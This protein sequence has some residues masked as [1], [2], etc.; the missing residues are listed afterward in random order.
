MARAKASRTRITTSQSKIIPSRRRRRRGRMRVASCVIPL[1]IG[2]R[3]A[4]TA[5]EKTST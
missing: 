4:Q 2:Q 5:N 1:I 3:S